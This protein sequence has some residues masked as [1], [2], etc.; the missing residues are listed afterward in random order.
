MSIVWGGSLGLGGEEEAEKEGMCDQY[1]AVQKFIF[2]ISKV[3]IK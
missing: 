2:L 3:C 1:I